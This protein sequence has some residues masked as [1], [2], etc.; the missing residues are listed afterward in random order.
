MSGPGLALSSQ[1]C[2]VFQRQFD[3]NV[4]AFHN[5]HHAYAPA[6]GHN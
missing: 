2:L 3:A 4:P 5:Y 6:P 1:I